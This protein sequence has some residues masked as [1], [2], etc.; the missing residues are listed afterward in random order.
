MSNGNGNGPGPSPRWAALKR[1][2]RRTSGPPEAIP[3]EQEYQ[4]EVAAESP[5]TEPEYQEAATE[6]PPP[7]QEYQETA[8]ES[9]TPEPEYQEEVAAESPPTE[10]AEPSP[11]WAALKRLFRRTSGPPEATPAEPEYQEDVAVESPPPEPEYQDVPAVE[12]PTPGPEQQE[13]TA[14]DPTSP[15]LA[16]PEVAEADHVPAELEPEEAEPPM[17][18]TGLSK[19]LAAIRRTFVRISARLRKSSTPSPG[20][21]LAVPE[22]AEDYTAVAPTPEE[23]ESAPPQTALKR[24]LETVRLRF[25]QLSASLRKGDGPSLD[26]DAIRTAVKDTLR[27][28][29]VTLSFEAGLVRIVVLHGRQV[30][31]WGTAD[32]PEEVG[33]ELREEPADEDVSED[34]A[35]ESSSEETDSASPDG[36]PHAAA[37]RALLEEHGAS[38]GHI[39]TDISFEASLLRNLTIPDI[40]GTYINQVV[41]SEVVDTVPF[42]E[43]EVQIAW[44]RTEDGGGQSI[45]AIAVP[46]DVLERHVEVLEGAGARL[47]AA[48]SKAIALAYVAGTPDAIVV[49]ITH[50]QAAIVLVRDGVPQVVHQLPL[51]EAHVEPAQLAEELAGGVEQMAGYYEEYRA[52]DASGESAVLPVVLTGEGS[53]QPELSEAIGLV[54]QREVLPYAPDLDYPEYFSPGEY[55]LNLGL[56]L[57]SQ[58]GAKGGL[59]RKGAPAVTVNLLPERYLPKPPPVIPIAVFSLLFVLGAAAFVA[60]GNVGNI[61]EDADQKA[62]RVERNERIFNIKEKVSTGVHGQAKG[63]QDFADKLDSRITTIRRDLASL[64][65]RLDEIG[66]KAL[67]PNVIVPNIAPRGAE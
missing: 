26:W 28:P 46:K 33:L 20:A 63:A 39:I 61:E 41:N 8:A 17:P 45:F 19:G 9:P 54:M 11:R 42:S 30:V 50:P 37:L 1:L 3:A 22:A 65:A 60:T 14:Y 59:F 62:S 56:A 40:P 55:V 38:R 64:V 16:A 47:K 6:S 34:S 52:F 43:D 15:E 44:Q 36:G 2:F 27:P 66:D 21:E 32:L 24:A 7:K 53:E 49:D 29:T 18:E 31:A 13:T 25:Q 67:P 58:A 10:Y 35:D 4:E 12:S 5:P 23:V 51:P 57:A 48:Y